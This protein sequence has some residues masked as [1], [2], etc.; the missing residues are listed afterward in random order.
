MTGGE[1]SNLHSSADLPSCS[2]IASS[3]QNLHG[4]MMGEPGSEGLHR[5]LKVSVLKTMLT[6]VSACICHLLVI[7][8]TTIS[9]PVV[10]RVTSSKSM[11]FSNLLL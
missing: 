6:P 1:H 11:P 2:E 8:P 5:M 3:Q 10:L 9:T 7:A 4:I